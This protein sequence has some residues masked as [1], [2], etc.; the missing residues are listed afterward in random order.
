MDIDIE[1]ACPRCAEPI[2][3]TARDIADGVTV[4]CPQGHASVLVDDTG[5]A[6]RMSDAMGALTAARRSLGE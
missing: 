1:L 3:S 6:R 4:T 2:A 5:S